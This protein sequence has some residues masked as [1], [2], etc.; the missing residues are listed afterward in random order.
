MELNLDTK[1]GDFNPCSWEMYPLVS[2]VEPQQQNITS[3]LKTTAQLIKPFF[4][5]A[6]FDGSF[7]LNYRGAYDTVYL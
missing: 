2:K 6:A 4:H 5:L 7:Q 1:L 3:T